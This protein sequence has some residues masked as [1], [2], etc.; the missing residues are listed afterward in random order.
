[1][2]TLKY[3]NARDE[4]SQKENTILKEELEERKEV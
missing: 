3:K 1:M 4:F 2:I